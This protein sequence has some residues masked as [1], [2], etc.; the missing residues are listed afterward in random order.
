MIEKNS[1]IFD[2][3]NIIEQKGLVKGA[4][5][6]N[7]WN[8]YETLE[9][10]EGMIWVSKSFEKENRGNICVL[11]NDEFRVLAYI[12]PN[13]FKGKSVTTLVEEVVKANGTPYMNNFV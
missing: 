9:H 2:V 3:M 7:K 6:M 12:A 1:R 13:Q 8:N 4:E 10:H 5:N 11:H